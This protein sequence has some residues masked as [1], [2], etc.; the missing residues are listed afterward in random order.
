MSLRMPP[1]LQSILGGR[2]DDPEVALREVVLN[3]TAISLII[4]GVLW[5]ASNLLLW[6]TPG[7]ET[8]RL[9][10]QWPSF[11]ALGVGLAACA[12]VYVLSRRGAVQVTSY[13]LIGALLGF[14]TWALWR[15]G[16]E[17][18]DVVLYFLA[19]SLAGLLLGGKG[20]I[21]TAVIAWAL[22]A[23]V[24]LLQHLGISEIPLQWP[25]LPSVLSLGLVLLLVAVLNWIGNRHLSLALH[26]AHQQ[27]EE[28]QAARRDQAVL[29]NDLQA[30]TEQQA[31]LLEAIEELAAPVIAVHDQIIVLPIVGYMDAHRADLI[32]HSLLHG[33]AEHGAKVAIIDLTGL[34]EMDEETVHHLE[35]MG[36]AG[37]LL[38]AEVLLVGLH[39]R[40][41]AEMIRVGVDL[42]HLDTKRNLQ[43]GV[44][45]A[46]T[47]M[48]K[49]I[50]GDG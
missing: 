5:L 2:S 8:T 29:L 14:T 31:R 11:A 40:S 30:R 45:H 27:A 46:L 24:G 38:G 9:P 13:V 49:R 41:A 19:V 18:N 32:R 21:V 39:A 4:V 6:L 23:V 42:R 37:R 47:K 34:L 3:A 1:F 17:I 20:S 50:V 12:A 28:L 16:I 48:S 26:E 33:I 36:Q 10:M 35:A 7:T 15:A 44:E 25:L 43:S 22:Y